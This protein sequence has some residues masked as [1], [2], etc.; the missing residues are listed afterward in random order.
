M[1][2][3]VRKFPLVIKTFQNI[4][5][6][7][8]AKILHIEILR[9][10]LFLWAEIDYAAPEVPRTIF[11]MMDGERISENFGAY[12]GTFTL[13]NGWA[14]FHAYDSKA[15]PNSAVRGMI[16]EV[17]KTVAV[18][19]ELLEALAPESP[20]NQHEDGGCVWCEG[21]PPGG[22]GYAGA[23][24]EHHRS[25]CAWLRSRRLLQD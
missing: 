17:P 24:A 20:I 10:E 5:L 14:V 21:T 23:E 3:T 19:R 13:N 6:R 4:E 22:F 8:G 25:D 1:T 15:D 7:E 11:L 12:L 9:D 16:K 2:R 18:P